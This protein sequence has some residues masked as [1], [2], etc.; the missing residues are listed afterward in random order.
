MAESA[1][2]SEENLQQE[3]G[4]RGYRKILCWAVPGGER[5]RKEGQERREKTGGDKKER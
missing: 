5:G 1:D 3:R 2:L 4:R